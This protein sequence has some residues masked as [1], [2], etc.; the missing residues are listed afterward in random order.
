[1][2]T[3]WS[4]KMPFLIHPGETVSD[5]LEDRGMTRSELAEISGVPEAYL[6]DVING[7]A[8]ITD[9]LASGL[10]RAFGAPKSFWVNLQ[11][12]YDE[13]VRNFHAQKHQ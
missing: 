4:A 1:M 3:A 8:G 6:N 2:K 13:E 11:A 5:L 10:D 12:N 7:K 9:A